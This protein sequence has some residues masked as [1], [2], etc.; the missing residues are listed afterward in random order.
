M[1]WTMIRYVG[2][3]TCIFASNKIYMVISH[4]CTSFIMRINMILL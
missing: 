2:V 3:V 4:T 1:K